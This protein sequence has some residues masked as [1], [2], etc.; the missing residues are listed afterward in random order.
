MHMTDSN[1]S[2]RDVL[3]STA[4]LAT[5]ATIASLG[6]N[7]AWAA[8]SDTIKIGLVGCGGRGTG[9]AKDSMK[10]SKQVQIGAMGDLFKDRLDQSREQL[11][12]LEQYAVKY[13]NAFTGFDAYKKVIDS[14]ISLVL[15]CEPPGFRPTSYRY[16][17]EKGRN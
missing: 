12:G 4:A 5:A 10:G 7:F 17:I 2:R 16:A 1:L 3:K 9:A 15:L 6:T 13:E 14:D 8:G 11:K